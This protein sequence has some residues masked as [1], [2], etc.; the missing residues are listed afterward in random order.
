MELPIACQT[1]L[2]GSIGYGTALFL[3]VA[4]GFGLMLTAFVPSQVTTQSSLAG[5]ISQ[6]FA[7]ILVVVAAGAVLLMG[8]VVGLMVGVFAGSRQIGEPGRGFVAAFVSSLIGYAVLIGV[9]L[10]VIAG[11]VASVLPPGT[12]AS[13]PTP[14]TTSGAESWRIIPLFLGTALTSGISGA[15]VAHALRKKPEPPQPET[16]V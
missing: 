6:L 5:S 11:E 14:V 12:S 13:L 4:L 15:I 9:I 8:P 3:V 2:G 16:T 10:V 1:A 7:I